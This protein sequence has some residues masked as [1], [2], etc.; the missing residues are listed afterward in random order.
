MSTDDHGSKEDTGMFF[1]ETKAHYERYS[2]TVA[3]AGSIVN[4]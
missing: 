4:Y 1:S 2:P 3:N